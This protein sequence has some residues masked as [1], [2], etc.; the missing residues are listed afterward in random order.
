MNIY[1]IRKK[2]RSVELA[3]KVMHAMVDAIDVAVKLPEPLESI[4][5]PVV[6]AVGEAIID[7]VAAAKKP[8]KKK[9]E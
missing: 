6:S 3:K 5:N 2:A 9:K 8:R 1:E 4:D 7:A